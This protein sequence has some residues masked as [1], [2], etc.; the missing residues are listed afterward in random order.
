MAEVNRQ[1]YMH[2]DLKLENIL[3]TDNGT[4]KIADFGLARGIIGNDLY[5]MQRFSA[6]GTPLYTAPNVLLK[7]EYSA[8]CD[9]FSTGLVIYELLTGS[10]LFA[11]AKSMNDLMN[12]QRIRLLNNQLE[13]PNV[14]HEFF[15]G[16]LRSMITFYES[17]RNDFLSIE[18]DV[19]PVRL[20]IGL[21]MD[22]YY[23]YKDLITGKEVSE[24]KHDQL[25]KSFS[26]ESPKNRGTQTMMS[27]AQT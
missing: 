14:I 4:V 20:K 3:L 12:L 1:K 22:P 26:I 2:R 8:K 7:E 21:S 11:D 25:F 24:V 10:H 5:K 16:M 27:A 17:D 18:S 15:Q 6:K 23:K 19:I 13:L 9:V